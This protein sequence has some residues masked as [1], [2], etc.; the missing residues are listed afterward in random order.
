MTKELK[1]K[2]SKNKNKCPFGHKWHTDVDKHPECETCDK[3]Q[4]C[5]NARD[6]P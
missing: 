2:Q 5:I 3:W 4:D 6:K 1:S